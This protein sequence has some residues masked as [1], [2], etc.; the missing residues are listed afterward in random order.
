MAKKLDEK[1]MLVILLCKDKAESDRQIETFNK[2]IPNIPQDFKC[3]IHSIIG[4]KNFAASF[5]D[6]QKKK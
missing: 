4:K 2:F 3:S 5:N 1:K 6:V